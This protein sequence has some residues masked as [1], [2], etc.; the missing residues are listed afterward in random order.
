MPTTPAVL[1]QHV[2][3]LILRALQE[4]L[5]RGDLTSKAVIPVQRHIHA[6]VIAKAPGIVAGTMIARWVFQTVDRRIRCHVKRMD[7]QPVRRGGVIFT[8]HGPAQSVLATERTALNFLGHLSG[9]ATL[10]HQFVQ[11]VRDTR[12]AI[13]DTRKTLPGLRV[14]EKY[15]VRVGGGSNHRLGLDDAV[16]IKTNHLRALEKSSGGGRWKVESG[17]LIETAIG[18][19]KRIRPKKF[20]EIEVTNMREFKAA[21]REKPNAILLDNWPVKEIRRAVH[22]RN[23]PPSTFHLPPMLE[24][25]GGVTLHNVRAI[26]RTGVDRISVGRLTHSAPVLDAALEVIPD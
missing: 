18:R 26:A 6:Q 1:R 8:V 19:A 12:A 11:K 14:L 20:V 21:L 7:G 24:V 17:K 25:S 16:L 3:P 13:F 23:L 10:T 15:A 2:Q 22:L 9:I 5:G 4:D